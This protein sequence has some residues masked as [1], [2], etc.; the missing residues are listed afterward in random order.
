[1]NAPVGVLPPLAGPVRCVSLSDWLAE[2]ESRFGPDRMIW[3]FVCPAC[4]VVA[5]PLNWM[6][7][8]APLGAVAFACHGRWLPRCRAA[9]DPGPGPCDYSGGGLF[10][11]NPVEILDPETR[12]VLCRKF[13]FAPAPARSEGSPLR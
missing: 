3:R 4:G 10:N 12:E 8:G 7:V 9:F 11:L 6:K 13:D 2:G 5:T 1:M